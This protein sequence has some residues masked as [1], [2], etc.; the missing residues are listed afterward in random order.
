MR[1]NDAVT[2]AV[3]LA[4]ALAVIGYAQT[5]PPFPGQKY[6]PA[7]FPTL[8]A[9]GL[10]LCGLLLIG[11]GIASRAPLLALADWARGIWGIASLALVLGCLV[12]YILLAETL[13]FLITS[14]AI[15]AVL[16]LWLGARPLVA[17]ATSAAATIA[18]DQFFGQV[19]RVPLPRG[20]LNLLAG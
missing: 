18:I 12:F 5:F 19:L 4:F 14:F 13:G 17:L 1:A 6:G 8:M 7:L 2:G 9:C 16:T 20:L 11:R 3:L 10:G 15:L